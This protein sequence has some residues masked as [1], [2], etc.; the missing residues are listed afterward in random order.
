MLAHVIENALRINPRKI[1]IVVGKYK[2]IIKD[3]LSYYI[4]IHSELFEFV[5]Q[6]EALGTGHAI[7]CA[8]S[9][10]EY[11]NEKVIILSGDVP[12][13]TYE[14][15]KELVEQTTH[16]GMLTFNATNPFGYGR[17]VKTNNCFKKIVEEKDCLEEER[18][19]RE[20]NSGIYVIQSK[21]LLKYIPKIS[22]LNVAKEYYLTDV[23]E[24]I[25]NNENINVDTLCLG[26]DKHY[27]LK[28]ANT[29]EDLMELNNFVNAQL[30]YDNNIC[31]VN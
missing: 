9:C 15:M 30:K 18:E 11:N 4:D 25:K 22:N 3:T 5:E 16:A 14:T 28:G 17:I 24:I 31:T 27:E 8:L 23:F 7:Q 20:V 1:C 13:L 19:I 10:L 26:E 12:L 21:L 6:P 29:S 2:S